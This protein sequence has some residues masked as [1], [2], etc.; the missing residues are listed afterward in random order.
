MFSETIDPI[1]QKL[2]QSARNMKRLWEEM[3]LSQSVIIHYF[4]P[5]LYY[6]FSG[7]EDTAQSL[8]SLS[9]LIQSEQPNEN[10]FQC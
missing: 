7:T 6:D 1:P 4:I 2:T 9:V 10:I 8:L 5:T 3:R